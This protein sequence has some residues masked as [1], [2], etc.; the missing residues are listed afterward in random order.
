MRKVSIF[1]ALS[2]VLAVAACTEAQK[3]DTFAVV[4]S[5]VSAADAGFQ[6]YA[7]TGR[8]ATKVMQDE[9]A[10]VDAA[11]AVCSGPRP[12]DTR[13]VL[14]AV[15]RALTAIAN[16]TKSARAQVVAG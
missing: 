14:V 10:A 13:S 6:I 1:A 12:S 16:A 7:S 3:D 9:A 15:Q 2:C 4:C 8:V 11:Q 5:S